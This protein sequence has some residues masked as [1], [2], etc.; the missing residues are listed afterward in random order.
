MPYSRRV[1]DGA[2]QVYFICRG[3]DPLSTTK[4][5]GRA[6]RMFDKITKGYVVQLDGKATLEWPKTGAPPKGRGLGA[7]H[8][9][10]S[11]QAL[12]PKAALQAFHVV[13]DFAVTD[14]AG[15]RRHL[16]VSSA[17]RKVCVNQFNVQ[18]PLGARQ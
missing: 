4:V 6:K 11:I 14:T 12:I 15:E 5:K 10:F 18:I 7:M 9:F 13:L 1:G 3:K 2:H 17:F 8:R 16:I